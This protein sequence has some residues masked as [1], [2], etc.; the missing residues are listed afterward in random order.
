MTFTE[1]S[2][3]NYRRQWTISA[4]RS[5]KLRGLPPLPVPNRA[6]PDKVPIAY[7]ISGDYIG[8][9]EHE[10]DCPAGAVIRWEPPRW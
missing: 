4:N 1:A 10:D 2:K 6:V 9:L 8:R 3:L 5:R 7:T